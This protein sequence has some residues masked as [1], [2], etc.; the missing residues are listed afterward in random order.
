MDVH[1]ILVPLDGSRAS[2]TALRHAVAVVGALAD[3]LLL[4]R[5][6]EIGDDAE[7]IESRF[8]RTEASAYL[9]QTAER[10]T[11][12]GVDVT[13]LVT[14]GGVANEIVR[15]ANRDDVSLVVLT[16]H[17]RGAAS[18]FAFGGTASKVLSQIATSVMVVRPLAPGEP[19]EGDVHYDRVLV[20]VDG[21]MPSE[22]AL[23]PA[24]TI[25][26][27]HDASLHVLHLVPEAP[28]TLDRLPPSSGEEDLVRHLAQ[29]RHDRGTRYVRDIE[30]TLSRDDLRVEGRVLHTSDPADDVAN[31]VQDDA[32]D[33]IALDARCATSTRGRIGSVARS[34]LDGSRVPVIVLQD[35]EGDIGREATRRWTGA[36][37]SG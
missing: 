22:W 12:G 26:Q 8:Q 29:L 20:P 33:L 4:L 37:G 1:R 19:G 35:A 21:S 24:A 14:V 30:G 27:R 9:D 34:L 28:R 25:A 16:S 13:T 7:G 31:V 36:T 18:G 5:V 6:L 15:C 2:E 11:R 10:L 32:I 17:G 23:F 3:G